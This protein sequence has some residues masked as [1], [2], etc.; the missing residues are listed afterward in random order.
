VYGCPEAEVQ[1]AQEL[2]RTV[3]G[4]CPAV[5]ERDVSRKVEWLWRVS[6]F[7]ASVLFPVGT[8][9]GTHL[10]SP[11]MTTEHLGAMFKA[12]DGT[13]VDTSVLRRVREYEVR[14]TAFVR[15]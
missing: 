9:E 1:L 11:L 6:V 8:I 14:C 10:R 5:E 2:R 7:Y 13:V 4:R 12:Y 15:P 3:G